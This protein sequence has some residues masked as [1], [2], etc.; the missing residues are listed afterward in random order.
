MMT[1]QKTLVQCGTI[2][3]VYTYNSAKT[4]SKFSFEDEIVQLKR[5]LAKNFMNDFVTYSYKLNISY[6]DVEDLQS[7]LES[8]LEHFAKRG[9]KYIAVL[10]L[11][12]KKPCIYLI[13]NKGSKLSNEQL[14]D[15]WGNK[16]CSRY[17]DYN[18][19]QSKPEI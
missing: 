8:F 1:E 14:S 13:T 16:V 7:H 19:L 9:L 6:Q 10:D 18:E 2:T 5:L 12:R 15:A 3:Y 11:A 17:V 4:I